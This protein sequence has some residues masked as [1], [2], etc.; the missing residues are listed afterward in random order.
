MEQRLSRCPA[1]YHLFLF[2]SCL[3]DAGVSPTGAEVVIE[4]SC[5]VESEQHLYRGTGT[6]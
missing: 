4:Q 1:P 3:D 5:G 2:L 6:M